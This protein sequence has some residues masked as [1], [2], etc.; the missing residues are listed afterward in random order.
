M[1]DVPDVSRSHL[2]IGSIVLLLASF[3]LFGVL[4]SPLGLDP[5]DADQP[6]GEV[7]RDLP[8]QVSPGDTVVVELRFDLEETRD[9][10]L[11][12]RAV[13]AGDE[14]HTD[15]IEATGVR[16]D[17]LTYQ[18]TIPD[19]TEGNVTVSG[20]TPDPVGLTGDDSV[21]V[22]D[23]RPSVEIEVDETQETDPTADEPSDEERCQ[24]DIADAQE[25]AADR[26]CDDDDTEFVCRHDADVS[27][28][29]ENDCE[30]TFLDDRDWTELRPMDPGEDGS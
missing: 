14:L 3:A 28:T 20:E 22:T 8:D 19:E 23:A 4:Y 12:E 1:V 10:L 18:F 15:S 13:L 17:T 27:Y 9:V 6:D 21:R 26:T 11:E 30:Y 24:D 7:I 16:N 5:V 2:A 29:V 25:Y